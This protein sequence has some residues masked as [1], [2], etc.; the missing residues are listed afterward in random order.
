MPFGP[1]SS[2]DDCVSKNRDKRS[3][4]AYCA[5]VKRKI[6]GDGNSKHAI[7]E[8]PI[9]M[10]AEGNAL[11]RTID[12]FRVGSHTDS[13][14]INREWGLGDLHNI[15]KA[16]EAGVPGRVPIKIGHTSD[17]FNNQLATSLGI[18]A[19]LL[20]G[21][22]GEGAASL[23]EVKALRVDGNLLRADVELSPPLA[24]LTDDRLFR[25]VS[26]EIFDH[27]NGADGVEYG[28]VLS[29][30]ALLGAQ[31]PAVKDLVAFTSKLDGVAPDRVLCFT[32]FEE[33]GL[34]SECVKRHM[35]DG[36]SRE[37]AVVKCREASAHR[38]PAKVVKMVEHKDYTDAVN[39]LEGLLENLPDWKTRDKV[40]DTFLEGGYVA[41]VSILSA[42]SSS[43]SDPGVRAAA[44]YALGILRQL[45]PEDWEVKMRQH[46]S[47]HREALNIMA[48]GVPFPDTV[49]KRAEAIIDG[50]MMD[51]LISGKVQRTGFGN[52]ARGTWRAFRDLFM[53]GF[54]EQQPQE[55][56]PG[57]V[58]AVVFRDHTED[59]VMKWLAD[60]KY[61]K[62]VWTINASSNRVVARPA[63]FAPS[64]L[65]Y[66]YKNVEQ[67]VDAIIGVP[68]QPTTYRAHTQRTQ[69]HQE[70]D[71]D[72][73][74]ETEVRNLLGIS[75]QDDIV[76][77]I[78]KLKE[79]HTFSEA[80]RTTLE[81]L[82]HDRRVMKYR[83][84]T[85]LL[86]AVTGK[87]EELAGELARIEE[88]HGEPEAKRMLSTWQ[89]VQTVAEKAGVLSAF[90]STEGDGTPQLE[91]AKI[92][93]DL[94]K[95]RKI[96][97]PEATVAFSREQQAKFREYKEQARQ[98]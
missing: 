35:A 86:K 36:M 64:G 15:V 50:A 8:L 4:Q 26:S 34:D 17:E 93:A 49:I 23:G 29:A 9:E 51:A 53:K 28:P 48:P 43:H 94:A 71:M 89:G 73:V 22:H 92:I 1:Y 69:Y 67:G 19:E 14:G 72:M 33:V 66:R 40:E 42:V 3:P 5:V 77:A 75:P 7:P 81:S 74:K 39:K 47:Q 88:V 27:R 60:H 55:T 30:L 68:T 45:P 84:H 57:Q 41:E 61:N 98:Q 20:V 83:I 59:Q 10:F 85:D 16:F 52:T 24:K 79:Q 90:A 2:F 95:E 18:P 62:D 87:P 58:A 65:T 54:G 46:K 38:E 70:G 12:I 37:E 25:D 44:S 6:E 63:D 91:G 32:S 82:A 21:E 76:A 11:I 31:R 80:E 56:L 97:I 13:A 96:S 78:T